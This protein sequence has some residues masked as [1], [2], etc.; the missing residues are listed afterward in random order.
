M[1]ALKLM[2]FGG[3][4]PAID[5]N[6]LP[7]NNAAFSQ[8]AWV[9]SGTIEGFRELTPVHVLANP[10]AKKAFRIPIQYYDKDHIPDSYWLEFTTQDV[11]VIQSPTADDQFE[12]FYW[13][14][15]GVPPTYNT[16]ARIASGAAAYKLGI[17]APSV[18]PSVSR[19]SGKYYLQASGAMFRAMGG[20]SK[21][22]NTKAYTNDTGSMGTGGVDDVAYEQFGATQAKSSTRGN[23]DTSPTS[24]PTDTARNLHALRGQNAEMRYSTL[25]SGNHITISDTGEV[26]TGVPAQPVTATSTDPYEGMGL[27]ETRAYV[28][29]W[30]SE[31]GEE[32]PPSPSTLYDGWSEDP[33]VIGITPPTLLDTTDR[34]LTKVR[35]YR[36]IT[37]VGGAT[38][39]FRVI[40]LDISET[41]FTDDLATEATSGNTILESTFW[42]APP[43]GLLGMV[44]MPNGIIAGWRA[45]EIW[46]CE[47]YRPHA[48]PV[49]Y[50]L[51][52]EFPIVGFGVLGQTL[53]ALTSGSPYAISGINPASMT[54]SRI[55]SNQACLSRGSI[56]NTP[57]GVAYAS[58]DGVAVAGPS[59]A[60]IVTRDLITK[61]LWLDPDNYLNIPATRAVALNGGYYAWGSVGSGCFESTAFDGGRFLQDDFTGSYDA[62]VSYTKLYSETPTYNCYADNWTGEALVVRD[63]T[64]YWMD[65]ANKRP[66]TSYIWRSKVFEAP[67]QR[68]FEAMRIWFSLL[69]DTPELNPVPNTNPVQTLA[70]DQWGLARVYADGNLKFTR[71]LRS[72]GVLFRLPSGFKAQF[73]QVEIEARVKINSVE[74]ATTAKELGTV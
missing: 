11:D 56:V 34:A 39:F 59:G 45:N 61:D 28:Y 3:M 16:K 50:T 24:V 12:R 33:W 29:T 14:G 70:E 51:A 41:S 66:H 58:P 7:Q 2:N 9:Y 5:E 46:F 15:Q 65:L 6:L 63:G 23:L 22:Y 64:V 48:W 27:Q 8:N 53:V 4:I 13:A 68:S 18:A 60:E 19:S 38:T 17:P 57:T 54:L 26:T 36:T 32:G 67:N 42:T 43:E 25:V 21:L 47:P 1:V 10:L 37:A 30:V 31:Y 74:L 44:A 35:I 40:E 71:E 69:N 72:S 73:W 52:V 62:R 49:L 20:V 55:A